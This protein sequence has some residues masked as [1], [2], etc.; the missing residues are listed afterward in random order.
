MVWFM[1]K[2]NP[3]AR[4]LLQSISYIFS[5]IGL[6]LFYAGEFA[7]T[8]LALRLRAIEVEK[9]S[10]EKIATEREKQQLL[11]SQNETLEKQVTE[12]TAALSESLKEL[13]ETQEQLIQR[14]KMAS[15]GEL[16]AGIAHEIQNPL[17]F[18]NNF[19][20][21]NTELLEEMQE[22]IDSG[23]Q[24]KTK[25]IALDI[26]LNFEKIV[27]HGK[28]AESIVKGMLLHSRHSSGHKDL[29]DINFLA[30]ECLRLSYHG[31]RAKDKSFNVKTETNF[32]SSLPK[33][34]I[35]TQEIGRVFLNLLTNAFYSVM[36]KRKQLGESFNPL[37]SI[38]TNLAA[39]RV[40]ISIRDN[41]MGI[42]EKVTDKIF[43]PFFTTKPAGEGTGLGL[44]ISYDI[45]KIHGG[46]LKIETRE[47]E[48][49]EF[50]ITLPQ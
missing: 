8:G 22:E 6:S 5:G 14:E 18:V 2:N 19:S 50:I 20:E 7:R 1:I 41:G 34:S 28:R 31:M 13:K 11:S 36:Q 42:P 10:L 3:D 49:A 46:D 27:H 9:L 21:L 17:N 29:T 37:V 25:M 38:K 4:A 45:I 16:T 35:V 12:R 39:A 44:S 24:E 30:D 15:L 23:N 32:D 26:K 47:G 40:N 43:L 33:I 48:F